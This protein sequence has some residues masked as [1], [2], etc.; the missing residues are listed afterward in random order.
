MYNAFSN[1]A[2]N[3]RRCFTTHDK[4]INRLTQSKSSGSIPYPFPHIVMNC[5]TSAAGNTNSYRHNRVRFKGNEIILTS[6]KEQ[7]NNDIRSGFDVNG[8]S[9]TLLKFEGLLSNLVNFFV[10]HSVHIAAM[11]LIIIII[12]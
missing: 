3:E 6:N 2:E 9:K 7:E 12:R 11:I 8:A 4:N 1:S 5:D 10:F